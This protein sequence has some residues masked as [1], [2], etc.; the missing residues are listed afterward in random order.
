MGVGVG[1][2]VTGLRGGQ[3][4]D[5]ASPSHVRVQRKHS[6]RQGEGGGAR[7]RMLTSRAEIQLVILW[8]AEP[9]F[10]YLDQ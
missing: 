2:I 7:L 6:W 5:A 3:W 9:V 8:S 1:G 10:T 4:A